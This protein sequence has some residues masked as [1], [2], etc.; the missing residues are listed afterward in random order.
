MTKVA[1]Y[2][3]ALNEILHVERYMEACKGADYIIVADT[4]STD[5]T[6]ERLREL[7]AT[8]Y[9]ISIKPWRFDD[10]R[11]AA[12]ALV[13]ADA[14]VCVILDLDEVPNKGFFDK[15]RKA[16][17]KDSIIGWITMDT[18]ATWH[19]DRL[20]NRHGWHWKYPCHEIQIYYGNEEVKQIEILDAV[21]KHIPDANKSR[22]QYLT[23]LQLCVKEYPDDPRM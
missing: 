23:I 19:R 21:I 17:R 4:G 13:P 6:P 8:V 9:D 14:D 11:N 18:G 5:G 1:V 16:W 20:H 7:G 3:I 15:V 22:S 10:A 2:S 12:L